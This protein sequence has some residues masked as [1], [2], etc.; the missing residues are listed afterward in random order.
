M[1]IRSSTKVRS[2]LN[3]I[4]MQNKVGRG[5]TSW[6]STTNIT[7]AVIPSFADM[8]PNQLNSPESSTRCRTGVARRHSGWA[9]GVWRWEDDSCVATIFADKMKIDEI[10]WCILH[11]VGIC[12]SVEF[13]TVFQCLAPHNEQYRSSEPM[14]PTVPSV[15]LLRHARRREFLQLWKE[16]TSKA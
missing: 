2:Q 10:W 12:D 14:V 8:L 7:F 5:Q 1:W 16:A 15:S 11:V 9:P 6:S 13:R 3:L 4:D